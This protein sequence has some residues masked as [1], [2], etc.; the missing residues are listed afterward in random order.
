MNFAKRGLP[1]ANPLANADP[2]HQRQDCGTGNA[3]FLKWLRT[4]ETRSH[5]LLRLGWKN[6]EFG[7]RRGVQWLVRTAVGAMVVR[8]FRTDASGQSSYT[9]QGLFQKSN[10]E[11]ARLLNLVQNDPSNSFCF[12]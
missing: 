5:V 12:Y 7:V 4:F 11:M 8:S 10:I 1:Q 9:A 3:Y 6:R 2:Q